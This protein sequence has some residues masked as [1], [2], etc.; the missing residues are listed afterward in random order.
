M[1]GKKKLLQCYSDTLTQVHGTGPQASCAIELTGSSRSL[2]HRDN[3]SSLELLIT[4]L[5]IC[6]QLKLNQEVPV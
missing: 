5:Y 6:V 4:I 1:Q 3:G 2:G